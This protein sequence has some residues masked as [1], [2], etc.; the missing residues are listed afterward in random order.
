MNLD[1]ETLDAEPAVDPPAAE[2]VAPTEPAAQPS[3]PIDATEAAAPAAPVVPVV[4]EPAKHEVIPL[5]RY[6]D[7]KKALQSRIAELEAEKAAR[8][9]PVEP[10]KPVEF[11]DDPK[12]YL[13]QRI[14]GVTDEAKATAAE[15][16]AFR[17]QQQ[18]NALLAE[19]DITQAEFAKAQ[20]DYQAALDHVRATRTAQ[21]RLTDSEATEAQIKQQIGREE[22]M[23]L[24]SAKQHGINPADLLYRYAQTLGYKPPVAAVAEPAVAAPVVPAKAVAAAADVS[25]ARSLGAGGGGGDAAGDDEESELTSALKARFRR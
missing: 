16:Q 21:L 6:L 20:P 8:A 10:A 9:A 25:A 4:P 12:G 11:M 3:P 7:D 24:V 13:D 17:E 19:A 5:A 14:Q 23:G 2:P 15:L 18:I 22:V 1:V